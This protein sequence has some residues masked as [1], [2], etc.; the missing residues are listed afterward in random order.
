MG[1][2]QRTSTQAFL[3]DIANSPDAVEPKVIPMPGQVP[4]YT[5]PSAGWID[6]AKL[7]DALQNVWVSPE[8][9][10]VVKN[11]LN[12]DI[13]VPGLEGLANLSGAI[14]QIGLTGSPF[15]FLQEGLQAVRLWL[16]RGNIPGSGQMV[17]RSVMNAVNPAAYKSWI[18]DRTIAPIADRLV[19]ARRH[20]GRGG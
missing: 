13:T 1:N 15:H 12:T 20:A 3:H 10:T 17:G 14:K 5:R 16:S 8:T 2:V 18:T 7:S 9:A 4:S 6:G 19:A 11:T